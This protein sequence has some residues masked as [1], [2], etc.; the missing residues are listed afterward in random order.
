MPDV[1][2][3]V[4]FENPALP[5][6]WLD[7]SVVIKLTK[8]KRGEN[9]QEI[10]VQ[11]GTR[12]EKLVHGLVRAGKLLCPE[13]DQEEEY[14][15]QRL[16]DQVHA[17]FASLSL[18]ISLAHRV[19]IMDGHVFRGMKAYANGSPAIDLPSSTY[20]HGDPVRRLE[21]VRKER[22]FVTLGPYRGSEMLRRRADAKAEIG[23]RWEELRQE[24]VA[25]RQ[26]YEKQLELEQRGYIDAMLEL[27]RRFERNLMAGRPNFWDFMGATGPL[28]YRTYWRELGGK[29]PDWE[30]VYKFFCSTYFGELPI[31]YIS[32][33]LGAELLT[34]NEPVAPGDPMDVEL[35]S[36]ALPVA[37]YVLADR[38]MELRIRQLRLDEKCGT[39]VYSMSSIEGL[40]GQLERLQ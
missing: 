33:R 40:F 6:L 11:R 3:K 15:A 39:Q 27:V 23:R 26:T 2:P 12:L 25:N 19:G 17:M 1:I 4:N 18:G 37:H 8:I 7:T 16:D 35:L 29:P 21:E 32:C 22:Y 36:V 9:L 30:G 38:R 13:S 34:G 24:L 10:E 31:P 20:F 5:T 28:L 14:V